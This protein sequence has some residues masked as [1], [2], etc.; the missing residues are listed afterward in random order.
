MEPVVAPR[1]KGP[2]DRPWEGAGS[3]EVEQL[4]VWAFREQKA[5]RFAGVGLYSAEASADGIVMTGRSSDGCGAL[6]DIEHLGCRIDRRKGIIKDQVHPAAEAVAVITA[7]IK[8]GELV[9]HYGRLGGRPDGWAEP[10]RWYRPVVWKT[11]G[12]E[13]QWER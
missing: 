6:A 9:R 11:Y 8:G 5:D 7:E 10:E 2:S 13:G 3:I 12:E 4:V 1:S